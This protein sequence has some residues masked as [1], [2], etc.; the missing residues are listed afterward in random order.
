VEGGVTI[1]RHGAQFSDSETLCPHEGCDPRV[2]FPHF[3][4]LFLPFLLSLWPPRGL[5]PSSLPSVIGGII[6]RCVRRLADVAPRLSA[7]TIVSSR[8]SY[9]D[10]IPPPFSVLPLPIASSPSLPA[11]PKRE[12]R[13]NPYSILFPADPLRRDARPFFCPRPPLFP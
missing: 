6:R 12:I 4:G 7:G 13:S 1:R 8:L 11:L 2:F 5:S 10:G 3:E 9:L